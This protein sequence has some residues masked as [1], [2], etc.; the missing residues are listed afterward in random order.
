MVKAT[1]RKPQAGADI[2]KFKIGKF[3]KNLLRGEAVG[4]KV[5]HVANPN[6]HAT[7]AG[8]PSALLWVHGDPMCKFN[9][10]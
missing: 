8:S 4:E 5:Q 3:L 10:F 7:N 6:A 2:F 9:H 1:A